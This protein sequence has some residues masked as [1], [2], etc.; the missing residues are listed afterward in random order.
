MRACAVVAGAV[1]CCALPGC[2]SDSG[3]GAGA[4]APTPVHVAACLAGAL[5]DKTFV[6]VVDKGADPTG[7]A[8]STAAIQAAIRESIL[9]DKVC[10]FPPG[11]YR[12]SRTLSCIVDG[13]AGGEADNE[14]CVLMGCRCTPARP[15]IF[16]ADRAIESDPEAFVSASPG[17]DRKFVVHFWSRDWSYRNVDWD[18][19]GVS[20]PDQDRWA[21]PFEDKY[22]QPN[23]AYNLKMIHLRVKIGKG[24]AGAVAVRM[25][26]AQG[27]GVQDLEIDLTEGGDTGLSGGCGSGG[28]HAD[29]T[30]IGGRVG[31]D[32]SSSQPAPTI[33][34]MTL[35]DQ[36]EAALVYG[37]RQALSAVGLRIRSSRS[38]GP[39][40]SVPSNTA[41]HAGH[42]ALVD[43]RIEF[44]GGFD[45]NVAISSPRPLYAKDVFFRGARTLLRKASASV[46]TTT[47]AGWVR[48]PHYAR[49]ERVSDPFFHT[50]SQNYYSF[51]A[52]VDG[53]RQP[54][55]VASAAV[56]EEPPATLESK[57]L[58]DAS[59]PGW[60]D[61][62]G[63]VNVLDY[64][65]TRN[66]PGDDDSV[67]I[68]A[69][70]E[71]NP[72]K[73]IFF[74][75]GVYHVKRTIR[76]PSG[77]TLM[78]AARHLS[79][80][81][82]APG[83][84]F[85]T[86]T[87]AA[88]P[89]PVVETEDTFGAVC[90]LA[91][92]RIEALK[93][94]GG[95]AYGLSWRS[96]GASIVRSVN[97]KN[98]YNAD[99]PSVPDFE[100]PFVVV[101]GNGG[102]RWYEFFNTNSEQNQGPDYR[103]LLVTGTSRPLR[104][105]QCNPE[106]AIPGGK[107][108]SGVT[109]QPQMEIRNARYVSIFGLKGEGNSPMLWVEGA[110]DHVQVFGYGGNASA[111]AGSSLFRVRECPNW[112]VAGADDSP[113]ATDADYLHFSGA[114]VDPS[115]WSMIREVR[116]G[117]AIDTQKEDPGASPPRGADRP[118]V[119]LRGNPRSEP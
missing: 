69:A 49:A 106:H 108:S 21:S 88:A 10:F 99:D 22:E 24:N 60:E 2:G 31:L 119:Y 48:L 26:G 63:A 56:P 112:L 100:K 101:S 109:G 81:R 73:V 25:Q 78:G 8:D 14:S 7:A 117:V 85:D 16:L 67:G 43:S 59:F 95:R 57:H 6:S 13:W 68:R 75:K 23:T 104:I 18:G 54:G 20:D 33:V 97:F 86:P 79:V 83:G 93:D 82:A 50:P 77:T 98:R 37:G 9:D 114:A 74:P 15:T 62:A 64:G 4:S 41:W 94:V 110:S 65:V 40:I 39:L 55:D 51:P 102:G 46:L 30:V 105:Y 84:D 44:D 45:G 52:W 27:S 28:A 5:D 66:S 107:T 47:H 17:S 36:S 90:H 70:I 11:T 118:A 38:A 19:N 42:L 61:P 80:L 32:L 113:R 91:F 116:S 71:A 12:I 115:E 92:L 53:L 3:S 34:G 111:M 1:L 103:H 58:W 72:G 87:T 35:V 76:V 89:K 29:V 96:G